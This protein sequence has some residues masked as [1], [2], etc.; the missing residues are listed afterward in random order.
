MKTKEWA[1]KRPR[2][3]LAKILCLL[4]AII[5][6]LYV[7]YTVAPEYDAQYFEIPVQVVASSEFSGEAGTLPLVRVFGTKAALSTLTKED[8]RA[9]VHLKDLSGE[10]DVTD[11]SYQTLTVKFTLPSGIRVDGPY[12]VS[13]CV[14]IVGVGA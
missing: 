5:F 8:I 13:V 6:W 11:N 10:S 3:W 1:A 2:H 14:H 12:T 9:E 7:M 4:V